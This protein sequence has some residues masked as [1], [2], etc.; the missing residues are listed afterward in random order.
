MPAADLPGRLAAGLRRR[1]LRWTGIEPRRV[2][3]N[4]FVAETAPMQLPK[5]SPLHRTAPRPLE[6]RHPG[7]L[8][9]FD[10]H[11][12]FY[13]VFWRDGHVVLVGPPLVNLAPAVLAGLR[14]DGLPPPVAPVVRNFDRTDV[15][16]YAMS[17]RPRRVTLDIGGAH[18]AARILPDHAAPLSGR[19]ALVTLSKNNELVW[20]RDWIDFH[21]RTHGV[22]AV[23][24]Y[25]NASDRYTPPELLH[26]IS[27]VPG[28]RTA[29]VVPWPFVFG[30][31]ADPDHW[32]SDYCQYGMLEDV[33]RRFLAEARAMFQVDVDELIVGPGGDIVDALD[34]SPTG[35]LRFPGRWLST[36]SSDPAAPPRHRHFHHTFASNYLAATKWVAIP[37]RIPD[38]V[39]MRVHDLFGPDFDLATSER[40]LFRHFKAI[41]TNWKSRRSDLVPHDPAIHEVD[42]EWVALMRRIGWLDGEPSHHAD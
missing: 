1:V 20:I 30:P 14:F 4:H 22:D 17:A 33:R 32:D 13:N 42:E 23:V 7:Y 29:I 38:A 19:R 21:V 5:S 39:Q 8:E 16:T 10:A 15:I 24:L 40:P 9:Q 41:S 37:G 12:L 2:D 18:L 26:H 11:T 31:Q 25:D 27:S 3:A 36:V 6:Y 34:R 28:I 35:A